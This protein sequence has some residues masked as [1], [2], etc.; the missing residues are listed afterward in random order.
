MGIE[1]G[2]I[3][4]SSLQLN[5]E[6]GEGKEKCLV[7]PGH[8]G[9]HILINS[10]LQKGQHVYTVGK[11]TETTLHSVVNYIETALEVKDYFHRF[12]GF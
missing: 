7:K 8:I 10:P 9:H 6:N 5:I 12:C 11:S 4:Y 1:A 2:S 3:R